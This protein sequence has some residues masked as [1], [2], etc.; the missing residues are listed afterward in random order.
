MQTV[1][2]TLKTFSRLLSQCYLRKGRGNHNL[3]K[4]YFFEKKTSRIRVNKTH[5]QALGRQID[6]DTFKQ[7]NVIR[8]L[9]TFP[10]IENLKTQW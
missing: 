5:S 9:K 2:I 10:R 3:L 8:L 4:W 7:T 1:D 6:F